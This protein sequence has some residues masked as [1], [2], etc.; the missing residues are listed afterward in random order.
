MKTCICK[1]C[2][3]CG[4]PQDCIIKKL[5][6]MIELMSIALVDTVEIDGTYFNNREEVVKYYDIASGISEKTKSKSI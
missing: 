4:L 3:A 1:A 6:K 2:H 5:D